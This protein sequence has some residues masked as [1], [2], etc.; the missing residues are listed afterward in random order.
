MYINIYITKCGRVENVV[1][2]RGATI[3]FALILIKKYVIVVVNN[4]VVMI[5][6]LFVQ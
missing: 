4:V 2:L 3:L 5:K 1:P 6:K